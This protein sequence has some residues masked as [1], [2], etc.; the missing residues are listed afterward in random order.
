MRRFHGQPNMLSSV[1]VFIFLEILILSAAI[2]WWR[3]R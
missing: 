3:Y 1:A 2:A